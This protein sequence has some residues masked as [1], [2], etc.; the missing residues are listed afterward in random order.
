MRGEAG[1]PGNMKTV[2][3]IQAGPIPGPATMPAPPA[4]TGPTDPMTVLMIDMIGQ[5][6]EVVPMATVM[7]KEI[8]LTTGEGTLPETGMETAAETSPGIDTT[9]AGVETI[10]ETGTPEMVQQQVCL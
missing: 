5:T 3:G 6:P 10:P 1:T 7:A 2:P 9:T 8:S 4:E